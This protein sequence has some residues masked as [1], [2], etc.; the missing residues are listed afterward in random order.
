MKRVASRL[1]RAI[2][3]L[4]VVLLVLCAVFVGVAREL[5]YDIDDFQAEIVQFVNER[6]ALKLELESLSGSWSGLAPHFTLR[7]LTVRMADST[8]APVQ[9]K[10]LDLDI[11]LLKSLFSLQPRVRLHVDGAR[12]SANYQDGHLVLSGFESL[13]NKA[14]AEGAAQ[15]ESSLDALL[16]QPRLTISNSELQV[17]GLYD[18]PVSLEAHQFQ[19]EAGR[20]RRYVLGDFTAHG[21]SD[22]QF[23]VK[24]K[25]S[26]SFLYPGSLNGGLYADVDAADWFAWIPADKRA[27]PQATLESLQGGASFWINFKNGIAQEIFSQFKINDLS[28]D[29]ENDIKPPH[30][31]NLQGK[32]RWAGVANQWRLDLQD[33]QL[34]TT[35]FFWLPKAVQLVSEPLEEGATRYRLVVDDVDIEPW[36]NYYLGTQSKEDK[37]HQTL[38]KLRPSGKLQEVALEVVVAEKAVQ[39][40]RFALNVTGF[41]NR[42]WKFIPGLH[43]LEINVWGRK[44]LTLFNIDENYLELNYPRL[45][46]DVIPVNQ[47]SAD[48]ILREEE[49]H[50]QLQSG[51]IQAR[52]HH[53]QGV[54]QLSLSLPKDKEQSPFLQLQA[55]LRNADG[56]H[57]SLYLPAGVIHE[58]L[59]KWLDEA[60]IDGHLLRGDIL[61][62]GPTRKLQDEPLGVLLG[63]T[64]EDGVL[65]F[66][67][68]W[69][70]PVRNGLADVVVDRGEVDARILAGTYYGQSVQQGSVTL[71]HYHEG[72]PHVLSVRAE[73]AG[74]AEQGFAILKESP[75]RGAIGEFI[76]D[77]TVQG[78]MAVDF[79]L[80]IP[81][82]AEF[83][84]Q[85]RSTTQVQLAQGDVSLESQ[86]I[87]VSNV[88][89]EVEFDLQKGL[90]SPR[91]SGTFLGG[92]ISGTIETRTVNDAKQKPQGKTTRLTFKGDTTVAALDQWRSLSLLQPVSGPLAYNAVLSIPLAAPTE[93]GAP[94]EVP[95]PELKIS[96]NLTKT[97]VDLPPPYGK[98]AQQSVP[99]SLSMG[100]GQGPQPLA[101]QYGELFKLSMIKADSDIHKLALH[102]GPGQAD[103]PDNNSI[104]VTGTLERFDDAQWKPVFDQVTAKAQNNG[105]NPDSG[106]LYRL[107]D[108][109]LRIGDMTLMGYHFGQTDL[110]LSRGEQ[111]WHVWIN[112]ELA[113]GKLNLPD[114]LLGPVADYRTQSQ[115]VVVDLERLQIAKSTKPE[116]EGEPGEAEDWQPADVSPKLFP[117]VEINL[118]Q[119][120][121]GES[122][123]GQWAIKAKPS[124]SGVDIPDF[125]AWVDG[126]TLTG[127]ANWIETESGVRATNVEASLK[128]KNA[129]EA[130]KAM[131]GT[132]TLSSKNAEAA[133]KLKWPGAPFEFALVRSQGDVSVSLKSGVFYNVNANAAGKLWGALNFETLMRRLQLDFDD[134]RENEMVYDELSGD[135]NLDRGILS[136]SHVKLNSPAIKMHASGK[137]DLE[138]DVLDLGLDVALPVTRNL[139]LPAAV[140]G[141]VPAAATAYVVEKMFG[142]QFDKLTTIKYQIKGTFDEP[143]VSVKDSFSF[144]PKQVGEAV[145]SNEKPATTPVEEA[146]P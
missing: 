3:S 80:D 119:F 145:I 42:P 63:F 138:H 6:S 44:G 25:V 73:A 123:F 95:S 106:L 88:D 140:I 107:D 144:I 41:Q 59:L 81:L 62:H 17:V 110:R 32:A 77:V 47:L 5:V 60:I 35:R 16:A 87:H 100:L 137:V 8:S 61:V 9:I 56:K 39:D 130:I 78:K 66:L 99:F 57:T 48:L 64:A 12:A 18:V 142:D 83:N 51:P 112:N 34:Q 85:I 113:T 86:K 133:G 69:T 76:E 26:G 52:T 96:S 43:D 38:S 128:A 98:P 53:A 97:V 21:P 91:I 11:L 68:E 89:A 24:G 36:V 37:L 101:L 90:S 84:D 93:N 131:G 30:I 125:N 126:V 134:I 94:K 103:L 10:T 1:I 50:W 2:L 143:L 54:T 7:N 31:L 79:G 111:R 33:L 127:H 105:E 139:V 82:Q 67:P 146:A 141:G 108:S 29:S 14:P 49:D 132:P 129:A 115:P 124:P 104:K 46:R 23:S 102:F 120:T 136:L 22:I 122:N 74:P 55:T 72:T 19:T 13:V 114:Y 58:S 70:E 121:V 65:Q 28:I 117:P 118:A 135:I 4:G 40:Y 27:L 71:P 75:L 92:A 15:E 116:G 109:S 45:F 20:R